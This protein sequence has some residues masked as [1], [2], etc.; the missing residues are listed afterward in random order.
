MGF[1]QRLFKSLKDKT[2]NK[3]ENLAPAKK[4][5]LDKF[6]SDDLKAICSHYDLE[7]PIFFGEETEN[8]SAPTN[9][10]DLISILM[11][12]LTF[13]QIKE[14]ANENKIALSEETPEK[15]MEVTEHNEDDF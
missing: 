4:Q 2:E 12:K 11:D 9:R 7:E 5:F 3:R 6:D 13:D 14:F 15:K 1:L 8:K 10:E